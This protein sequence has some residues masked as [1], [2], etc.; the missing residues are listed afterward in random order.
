MAQSPSY[1]FHN[2]EEC[3]RLERQCE[4]R[5]IAHNLGYFDVPARARVLDAGCGSG[6]MTRLIASRHPDSE[7]IGVDLNPGYVA[8]ARDRATIE[9]INN[10]SFQMADVRHLP[11][12]DAS[13][14]IVGASVYCCAR[15]GNRSP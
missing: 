3:E 15:S 5:G 10:S 11:F 12:D 2:A 7:V 14:D 4:L 13:F 9:G 8:W 1:P 6:A